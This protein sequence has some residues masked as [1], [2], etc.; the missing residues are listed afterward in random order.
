MSGVGARRVGKAQFEVVLRKM[1][2]H[3]TEHRTVRPVAAEPAETANILAMEMKAMDD[4]APAAH[5]P[6]GVG[7]GLG[8]KVVLIFGDDQKRVSVRLS[9]AGHDLDSGTIFWLLSDGAKARVPP[10]AR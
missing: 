10:Y 4:L 5:A 8:D 1:R 3:F 7:V 9:E 2:R 6:I